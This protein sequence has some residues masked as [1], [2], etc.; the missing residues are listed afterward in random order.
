MITDMTATELS[1]HIR[2]RDVSCVEVME[3]FLDRI[4]R[5]NPSVNAIVSMRDREELVA[6][7]ATRDVELAHGEYRGWMHGMPQAVKDLEMTAGIRTTWGSRV[8]A[9][10]V[11]LQDSPIVQ[12]EKRS[13]AIV[14]GKTNTPEFG[15]GSQTYNDVFGATRNAYDQ[16]RTAGGSS[17]GAAVALALR[18]VPVADGSDMM[19]SLRNPAAYNN[20]FGFRPSCGRVS[21]GADE[22]DAFGT[23]ISTAGP[24]GRCV[25]DVTRLVSVQAGFD[26]GS[27]FSIQESPA[28]FEVL[29]ERDFKGTRVGWLSDWCGH[30]PMEDG[31]LSACESALGC[32]RDIGCTVEAAVPEFSPRELWDA[33]VTLRSWAIANNLLEVWDNGRRSNVLK[34]EIAWEIR[35]GLK[36][37]A[38]DAYRANGVRTRWYRELSRM[39][40]SYTYLVLP[41]AQVYPFSVDTHWPDRVGGTRM[42][43]YHEWMAVSILASMSGCPVL[44]VPV[45]FNGDRLPMGMQVIGRYGDDLGVLQFGRAYEQQASGWISRR[46]QLGATAA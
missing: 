40:D 23:R 37:S 39:F 34:P 38:T 1:A 2:N 18:M 24:M 14:I 11:P 31:I 16:A 19:G 43:T 5:V 7:A 9:D 4:W 3:A 13:G 17:G 20:V 32:A 8:F 6:E 42:R 46:P 33:W 15:V 35:R 12:R 29:H 45:G 27:P 26:R 25:D 36:L 10:F 41:S 30:F 44:N 21:P 22:R 28:V